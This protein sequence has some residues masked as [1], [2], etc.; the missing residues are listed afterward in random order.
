MLC[1]MSVGW[2]C[3]QLFFQWVSEVL[4]KF[5][6]ESNIGRVQYYCFDYLWLQN[7]QQPFCC[8]CILS[9]FNWAVLSLCVILARTAVIWGL[10]WT[11]TSSR[12]FWQQ[13]HHSGAGWKA[14]VSWDV[15][16]TEHLFLQVE[17]ESLL[18]HVVSVYGLSKW[19]LQQDSW[20]YSE[21]YGS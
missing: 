17:S 3:H 11:G 20:T 2:K 7:K 6:D 14:A 19:Q 5:G 15:G 10:N 13:R 4:L 16:M 21:A 12:A 1:Y 9:R 8:L 18:L